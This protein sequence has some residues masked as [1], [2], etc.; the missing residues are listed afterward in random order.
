MAGFPITMSSQDAPPLSR[1]RRSTSAEKLNPRIENNVLFSPHAKVN[2]PVCSIYT[3][4]KAFLSTAGSKLAAVSV[5]MPA[6]SLVVH[7][8]EYC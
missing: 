1:L 4:V 3:A 5:R 2:V 6:Y 7:R 8:M